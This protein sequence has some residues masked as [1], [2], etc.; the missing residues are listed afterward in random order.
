VPR[1]HFEASAEA[2]EHEVD[3]SVREEWTAALV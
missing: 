1:A 3:P 2:H